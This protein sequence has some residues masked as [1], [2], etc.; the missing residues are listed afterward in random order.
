MHSPERS[1]EPARGTGNQ[2]PRCGGVLKFPESIGACTSCGYCHQIPN[3]SM[4]STPSTADLLLEGGERAPAAGR[5]GTWIVAAA[6][7]AMIGAAGLIYSLRAVAGRRVP[8]SPA[9][10][11]EREPTDSD[12]SVPILK[13]KDDEDTRPKTACTVIGY[14]PDEEGGL[15]GIVL[16]TRDEGKLRFAGVVQVGVTG[17]QS[18]S[19]R[20]RLSELAIKQPAVD[21]LDIQAVWIKPAFTCIVHHS[22]KTANGQ[23]KDPTFAELLANP[24]DG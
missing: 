11:A 3:F 15:S 14:V 20:D 1:G 16:A 21:G 13:P 22:G 17:W 23:V 5:F 18:R 7:V 10:S 8:S 12:H 2:C 19:A 6:L 4:P 9:A 24:N